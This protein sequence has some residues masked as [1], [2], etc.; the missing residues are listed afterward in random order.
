VAAIQQQKPVAV[1]EIDGYLAMEI[2]HRILDK[3]NN[4]SIAAQ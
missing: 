2:A 4:N 3:I 1:N